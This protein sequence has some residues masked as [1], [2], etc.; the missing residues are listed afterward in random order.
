MLTTSVCGAP[1]L[2]STNVQTID[3]L[4]KIVFFFAKNIQITCV[5]ELAI[6]FSISRFYNVV[7]KI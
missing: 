4:S 7:K 3:N 2:G 6:N 5:F 1:Q